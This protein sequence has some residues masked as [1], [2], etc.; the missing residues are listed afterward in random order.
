MDT[1]WD[2]DW[3]AEFSQNNNLEDDDWDDDNFYSTN[4]NKQHHE[5]NLEDAKCFFQ[6]VLYVLFAFIVL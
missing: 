4:W 1:E 3:D 2:D 6:V 5:N